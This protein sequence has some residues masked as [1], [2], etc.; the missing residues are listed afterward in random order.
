MREE[1]ELTDLQSEPI[2]WKDVRHKVEEGFAV[3]SCPE[4]G[5]GGLDEELFDVRR[6]LLFIRP[7]IYESR[8]V[9]YVVSHQESSG[10]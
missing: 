4:G 9:K 10:K 3:A 6:E 8:V 1:K 2:V 7:I 5:L